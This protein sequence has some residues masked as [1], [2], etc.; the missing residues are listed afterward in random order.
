MCFCN[1]DEVEHSIDATIKSE[2]EKLE[3]SSSMSRGVTKMTINNMKKKRISDDGKM[4]VRYNMT[5]VFYGEEA[6]D[7]V[8]ALHILAQTTFPIIYMD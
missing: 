5:R 4:L 8:S 6:N 3:E 2:W 1:F 7:L